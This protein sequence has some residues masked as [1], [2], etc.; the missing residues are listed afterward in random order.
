M[1]RHKDFDESNALTKAKHTFWERGYEGTS[2]QALEDALELKRTSIYNAFGNKRALF[3]KALEH[4]IGNELSQFLEA[5]DEAPTIRQVIQR[6][7]EEAI[8]LHFS[9]SHPGGCL[10]VLSLLEGYQHNDNTRS[11]LDDA[12]SS[13]QTGLVRRFKKSVSEGELPPHT[14]FQTKADEVVALIVGV[15]V[16]AKANISKKRLQKLAIHTASLHTG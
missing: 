13:L 2:I 4:Y 9:P 12:L 7:I 3:D 16:M 14:D 11:T 10:I 5:I 1:P 6:A 15:I 8:T